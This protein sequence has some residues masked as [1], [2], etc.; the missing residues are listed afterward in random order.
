MYIATCT[1]PKMSMN[2]TTPGA[3]K[4]DSEIFFIPIISMTKKKTAAYILDAAS[5]TNSRVSNATLWLSEL[6]A[7]VRKSSTTNSV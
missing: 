1:L 5:F 4:T 7:R 6:R 2:D 3:N